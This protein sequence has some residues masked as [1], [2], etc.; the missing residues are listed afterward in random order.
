MFATSSADLAFNVDLE[1]RDYL[2]FYLYGFRRIMMFLG[3]PTAGLALAYVIAPQKYPTLGIIVPLALLC[4]GLIVVGIFRDAWQQS[5]KPSHE[6]MFTMETTAEGFTI[7]TGGRSE[8]FT[9]DG[10]WRNVELRGH[11]LF[12]ATRRIIFIVPKRSLGGE[13]VVEMLRARSNPKAR[14]RRTE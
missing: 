11:F 14:E 1:F 4:I 3:P 12:F 5:K 7:R 8:S 2:A 9:W 13:R 10:L 6:R